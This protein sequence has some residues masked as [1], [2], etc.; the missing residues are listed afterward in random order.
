MNDTMA[1]RRHILE[2]SRSSGHGHL[3]SCFSIVEIL[4]AVYSVMRHEP[5]N[6]THPKRD[7]FILSKGHGSLA[8]YAT[9]ARLGYFAPDD[10]LSYGGYETC[11]GCHADRMKIP[12]LEASTGSLGHG[13][14][15]AVGMAMA[16]KIRKENRRVFTLIG[17]GEANEGSVWEAVLVSVAQKLNNLTVIYDNNR[18]HARGLQIRNPGDH[19]L[20]FGCDTVNVSGHD[21]GALQTVLQKTSD[22]VRVIIA[23]TGKGWP[24]PTF[25]NNHYAWHRRTPDEE[26]FAALLSELETANA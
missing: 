22:S 1:I 4:W 18:S 6:P 14:G 21:L 19:F 11:F 2:V 10:V 3:P 25:M 8:L 13:I 23:E 9:L 16:F 5:K 24:C 15:L 17:D 20:G 7:I 12:G 26:E